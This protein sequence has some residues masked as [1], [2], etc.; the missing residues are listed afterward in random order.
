[1]PVR[2]QQADFDV[3]AELA[4]L[5]AGRPET[6]A[7]VAFVGTVRDMS[8]GE[9]VCV[10]ELEHYPGMTEA[11]L[12]AIVE[13]ARRRWPVLEVL[14]VHRIGP[15]IASEQIVLAAV[16]AR[17]RGD[18]FA[19]CE[20]VMDYLKTRAP[21]WKKEFTANGPR[22]VQARASDEDALARWAEAGHGPPAPPV[23]TT[24]SGAC[25]DVAN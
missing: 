24:P 18:A 23:R 16:S 2:L 4:R 3:G 8:E 10:M 1:M 20:F 7:V 19:A 6:G 9:S 25:V 22:W 21:F 11:A 13:E 17:H 5:R 12:E 15:L 14:V